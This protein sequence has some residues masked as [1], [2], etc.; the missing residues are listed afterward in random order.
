M[1]N[2][3]IHFDISGTNPAA[4]ESFY[5]DLF[6][7]TINPIPEMNYTIVL[8]P[9]GGI[10]GGIG[11]AQG[12]GGGGVTFYVEVDDLQASLDKAESLG[13]RTLMAPMI[14]P[15]TVAL[16][17]FADPAGNAI[18]LVGSGMGERPPDAPRGA[19]APVTW[20]EVTGPDSGALEA[21]YTGLF[22]WTT[23]GNDIPGAGAYYEVDTGAGK[24]ISGGIGQDP[25]GSTRVTV[26]AEPGDLQACLDRAT[27]LGGRTILPPMAVPGGPTLAMFTDPEGHI[28][29][30]YVR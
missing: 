9:E 22:G 18:G 19:G 16:A 15:D 29:G 8:T 7:W 12:G 23:K 3:V 13:G 4:L 21:F 30:I 5:G 6:G 2:P 25:H 11:P 24:G 14:I 10:D 27:E 20:F 26:Y 28:F 17:M 1:G